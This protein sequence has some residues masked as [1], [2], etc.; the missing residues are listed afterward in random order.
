MKPKT[1]KQT[2]APIIGLVVIIGIF[3]L[4][5]I[6]LS[7]IFIFGA[8]AGVALFIFAWLRGLYLRRKMRQQ[9]SYV[10]EKTHKK[11]RVFDPDQLS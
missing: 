11:G 7:Y 1:F 4:S 5:I 10:N 9:F 3:V 6:F 2:L 8:I